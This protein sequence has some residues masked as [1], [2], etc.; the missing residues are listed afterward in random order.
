MDHGAAP[1][2]QAAAGNESTTAPPMEHGG[3]PL[4]AVQ[5]ANM[6]A[7]NEMHAPMMAAAIIRD[8][9]LASN[10]GMIAHHRGA[11]ATAKVKIAMG[12]DAASLALAEAIITAQ[13]KEIAD[14]TRWVEKYKP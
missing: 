8:P 7:T 13:E 11:I 2:V 12:K 4:D 14:M 1:A 3:K 5:Q 9:D 10:C 6:D